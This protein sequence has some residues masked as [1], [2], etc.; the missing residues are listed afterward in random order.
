MSNNRNRKRYQR[1][2]DV[3]SLVAL[4]LLGAV[5][6]TV[7]CGFVGIKN[8]HVKRSDERRSLVDQIR[9]L[10]KE[11]E[12][13]DLRI[14]SSHDRRALQ[15]ALTDLR[16]EL[17]PIE[18]SERLA[19]MPAPIPDG[20]AFGSVPESDITIIDISPPGG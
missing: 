2:L 9:V 20:L 4:L 11:V 7:A 14:A 10:E 15:L 1:R 18:S 16:S 8:A 19:G 5:G 17:V 12:T 3:G 13:I 6:A